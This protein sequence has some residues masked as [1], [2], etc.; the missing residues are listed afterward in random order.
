MPQ[1]KILY[2]NRPAQQVFN[3]QLM[4]NDK[5]DEAHKKI[6]PNITEAAN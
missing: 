4:K 6:G 5:V 1:P 2:K 3:T